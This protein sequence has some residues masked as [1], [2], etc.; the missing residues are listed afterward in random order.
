MDESLKIMPVATAW[1]VG[2][3]QASPGGYASS[4]SSYSTPSPARVADH[5][6][7]QLEAARKADVAQHEANA[8]ALENNMRV[9]AAV[10][11]MMNG[12]GMPTKWSERDL[13]SRSRYPKTIS[14][15]AGYITDLTR[16][17]KVSDGFEYAT[18]TYEELLRRYKEFKERADREAEE[19]K[20]KNEREAE[21][22]K[23]AR[24]A[25][26]EL[27]ELIL[28]WGL[29]RESTW[30]EV[31]DA[32]RDKHQRANLAVAMMNVRGDWSDGPGEVSSAMDRFTIE[33]TEDKDIA[34]S[35]LSNLGEGWDGD[36]RCFRDCTWN[37][38]E[39]MASL[40]E[41]LGADLALAHA[42]LQG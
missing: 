9:Q 27:A 34:N 3:C 30:P 11:A 24:L 23:Q 12:L 2:T 4:L 21:D 5:A 1:K 13:K 41:P 6:L 17:V 16:E 32:L 28:R 33:T 14:H 19:A 35:V 37:Y 20:R 39:L 8:P 38:N 15:P 29:P 7:A 42:R 10:T 26:V 22:A 25:N 31:L 40:P 18:R 36:G